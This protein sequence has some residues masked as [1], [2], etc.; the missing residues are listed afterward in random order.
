MCGV[1]LLCREAAVLM[2]LLSWVTHLVKTPSLFS[3]FAAVMRPSLRVTL[4]HQPTY[5]A[6]EF[7]ERSME[8]FDEWAGKHALGQGLAGSA[9]TL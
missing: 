9:P 6:A 1:F 4:S 2:T 5:R 8:T 3:A 7:P